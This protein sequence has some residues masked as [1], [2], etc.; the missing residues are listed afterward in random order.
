MAPP[1]DPAQIQRYFGDLKRYGAIDEL[2]TIV[3]GGVPV[4]AAATRAELDHAIL[5][6]NHRSAHAHLPANLGET[7]RRR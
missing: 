7:W 2:I 6:G 1:I 5:Y 4:N 3:T